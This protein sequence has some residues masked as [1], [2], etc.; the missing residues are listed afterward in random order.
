MSEY[1]YIH[2]HAYM[3]TQT[4]MNKLG[5]IVFYNATLLLLVS[6]LN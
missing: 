5:Y 2:S 6:L 4:H 3:Y 1:V